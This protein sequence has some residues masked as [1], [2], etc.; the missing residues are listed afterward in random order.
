MVLDPES[1]VGFWDL[2]GDPHPHPPWGKVGSSPLDSGGHFD[3][4]IF[5]QLLQK[6][7]GENG[8]RN[9]PDSSRNE[10][11]EGESKKGKSQGVPATGCPSSPSLAAA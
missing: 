7:E 6:D 1:R 4:K 10:A 8:M 2:G 11:L 3:P 5:A 9:E